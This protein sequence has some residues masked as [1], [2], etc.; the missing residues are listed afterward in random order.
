MAS[1]VMMFREMYPNSREFEI[2]SFEIDYKLRPYF[3]AYVSQG[4]VYAHI[5][6]GVS[7]VDGN[8]TAFLEGAWF[9]GKINNKR[10]MQWGGGSLF[11]FEDE[12]KTDTDGG[13]R[14]LSRHVTVPTIDLSQWIQKHTL[15]EDYV[16]LKLDVEGA[17]Y[18]ILKKMLN[19]DTF[20]WIDKYYGEF[21]SWQPT[22]LT[23]KEKKKIVEE[24]NKQKQI[25]TWAGESKTISDL[26][27]LQKSDTR[28]D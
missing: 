19:D 22:G 14:K 13:R 17:E 25:I 28:C 24:A 26:D 1:S 20:A 18:G 4:N 2:H 10:D 21:H 23:S 27:E 6:V 15:K 16:I 7:N 8:M 12:K 9:P 3:A 11:A 5:P